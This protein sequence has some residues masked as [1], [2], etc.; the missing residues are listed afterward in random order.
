MK[1]I[2]YL[3]ALVLMVLSYQ[4]ADAYICEAED[5]PSIRE[6]IKA[7]SDGDTVLVYPGTYYG[8][9]DFL[10]KNI[11]VAS[12]FIEDSLEETV[13]ATIIDAGGEGSVV[14]MVEV[15]GTDAGIIGF[16]L[17][18][19]SAEA[20][21]G[22]CCLASSA[23]ISYNIISENSAS[24]G[25][26]IYVKASSPKIHSNR[27]VSNQ[28]EEGAGIS[29][30]DG[31]SAEIYVNVVRNNFATAGGGLLVQRGSVP[32]IH[33]NTIDS[34]SALF[35]SGLA[36]RASSPSVF[37]NVISGNS[38]IHNADGISCSHFAAPI[39]KHNII[40]STTHG[41]GIRCYSGSEPVVSYNDVWKNSSGNFYGCWDPDSTNYSVLRTSS[42]IDAG[43]RSDSVPPGGGRWIDIGWK[44]FAYIVGDV[45]GD[46][47]ID[48]EDYVFLYNYLY[49]GCHPPC[50]YGAGDVDC[51]C[52]INRKD[53]DYLREYIFYGGDPPCGN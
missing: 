29:C 37:G 10:N 27:I 52:Q 28:A 20:G 32:T 16:T 26:G 33:N 3:L 39:I 17:T 15:D 40:T 8:N 12:Q 43:D 21:G 2:R 53:L 25:G 9:I 42:C 51:T 7:V 36:C 30:D 5:E 22:I 34:N 50:P 31:T 49:H 44:E 6:C 19:G 48:V 46:G 1:L 18:N 23:S 11:L 14:T 13:K 38:G 45:N 24:A 4:Q 47:R 35:G 41:W